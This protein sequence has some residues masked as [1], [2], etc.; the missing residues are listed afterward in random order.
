M[1]AMQLK[2]G[3][4]IRE[5]YTISDVQPLHENTI[6]I[7]NNFI[8]TVD[9]SFV[10][11]FD[12]NK[13]ELTLLNMQSNSYWSGSTKEYKREIIEITAN[14]IK[15]ESEELPE[16]QREKYIELYE[17]LKR[18]L[19]NPAPVLHAELDIR[20]DMTKEHRVILNYEAIKYNLFIDE[21]LIEEIWLASRIKILDEIDLEKFRVFLNEISFGDME[22]DHR[23]SREY[24]H[25]LNFGYPLISREFTGNGEILT[26]VISVE[27]RPV[28]PYEF[29]VPEGFKRVSLIEFDVL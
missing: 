19:E 27:K 12:L 8:K 22:F 25:L 4:I 2:A 5:R 9:G 16:N 10:T 17:N 11:I 3:W 29:S 20:V 15:K 13:G 6:F 24:L 21:Q 23:A 7:Q 18:D 1:L 14:K 28:A 26:E